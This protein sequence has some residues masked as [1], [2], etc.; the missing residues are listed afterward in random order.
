MSPSLLPW[1]DRAWTRGV[2]SLPRPSCSEDAKIFPCL[3]SRRD[4]MGW[5]GVGLKKPGG[6]IYEI[7]SWNDEHNAVRFECRRGISLT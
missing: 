3:T 7:V 4:E 6:A 1:R 5:D 2:Q